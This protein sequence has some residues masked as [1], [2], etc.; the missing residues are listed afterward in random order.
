MKLYE[1]SQ[2][3]QQLLDA[4]DAGEI[5]EEAIADTLEAVE[6]ELTDKIDNIAC[7]LK[8]IRAEADMIKA[9]AAQLQ[10]R[11]RSKQNQADKLAAYLLD[12]MK[13]TGKN[14]VETARNRLAIRRNPEAVTIADPTKFIEWAKENNKELLT[15]AP[16][17]PN[18]TQIKEAIKTGATVPECKI[19]RGERLEVR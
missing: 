5:P 17:V 13:Q 6:G 7:M 10:E 3:Y 16:P 15:Y 8:A 11:A 2:T 4:I 9:E 14:E 1:I 18:K 19:E 12:A